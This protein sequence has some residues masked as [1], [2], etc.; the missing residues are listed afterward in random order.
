MRRA[1]RL[2]GLL[3]MTSHAQ[4][5]TLACHVTY[6]GET[7]TLRTP[8]LTTVSAA[9][10]LKTEAFGSYFLFRPVFEPEEVKLYTY[11]DHPN[12]P[13]PLHVARHPHPAATRSQDKF[14]FSGEQRI[15]EPIRD[16][17]L[18]YW[19]EIEQ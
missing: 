12:G 7:K 19:C 5:A 13:L 2:V 18:A 3:L 11:A 15:Y 4:G 14:G 16:S 6:G 1:A 10:E 9:Y 8:Q 17:E